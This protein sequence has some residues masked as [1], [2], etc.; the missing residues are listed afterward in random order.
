MLR[1]IIVK[2]SI[3][4]V[5]WLL[6]KWAIEN[7]F[8]L[9]NVEHWNLVFFWQSVIHFAWGIRHSDSRRKGIPHCKCKLIQLRQRMI[10]QTMVMEIKYDPRH[11]L[12]MRPIEFGDLLNILWS[13]SESAW[14]VYSS[15]GFCVM[16][17]IRIVYIY[18]PSTKV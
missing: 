15:S 18:I 11:I 1:D 5:K 13:S 12:W 6:K 4:P 14:S 3:S 16:T 9:T 7:T 10:N 8:Y 2:K 17:M